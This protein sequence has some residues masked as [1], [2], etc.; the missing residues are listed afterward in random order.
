MG[1]FIYLSE[2]ISMSLEKKMLTCAS[3]NNALENCNGANEYLQV[4]KKSVS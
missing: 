3:I 2:Y 1:T 4:L